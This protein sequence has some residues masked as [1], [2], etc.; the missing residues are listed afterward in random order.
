MKKSTGRLISVLYR[1][2]YIY[3]N[4]HF[5]KI[6]ITGAEQPFLCVLYLY[7]G[8][9][10]DFLSKYLSV[11]KASTTR[12]VKSLIDKGLVEKVKNENDKR[13]N[14]IF[15]T[16]KGQSIKDDVFEVLDGWS[17]ILT[18]GMSP[19]EKEQAYSYLVRMVENVEKHKKEMHEEILHGKEMHEKE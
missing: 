14:V 11:D 8:V 12:V 6:N 19:E 16:D 13:E 2:G 18:D 3:K 10:Q 1:K 15:L 7:N 9:T 4:V 17:S 5:R